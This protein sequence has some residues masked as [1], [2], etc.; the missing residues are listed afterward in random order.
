MKTLSQKGLNVLP[1]ST[2]VIDA[3]FKELKVSGIDV[4]GFGA[5][6]PDFETPDN[7]KTAG[8]LAI[9]KGITRYT[10]VAGLQ[11]LREAVCRKFKRDYNLDYKTDQ[12]VV[13][14]GAKQ[15]IYNA[16]FAIVNPGDEVII[17]MP[18][19]ISYP[20]MAIMCGGIPVYAKTTGDNGFKVSA[21]QIEALVTPKT[22][23]IIL[24]SPSNPAGTV[25]DPGELD[26]IAEIV[27]K[28]DLYIISDEIYE[29]L[30]YDGLEFSSISMLG[31][32]ICRR[33]IIINGVSK[34][35]AMTGWRIGF[36]ASSKE[37]AQVMNNIQSHTTSNCSSIGQYA[38]IE[39]LDGQQE[40]VENMRKAFQKRAGL[41]GSAY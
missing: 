35:Y 2:L 9:E 27:I 37:L 16:L 8:K 17:P 40:D 3:M 14:N 13:S 4:L 30:I 32:E 6:E 24:N 25:Y 36:S 7:I 41:Y 15:S 12:I 29:K 10:P 38:S 18:Y 31:E 22:K 1:S 23:A 5:G 19:W 34:S 20:Q 28:H 21:E 11:E 26:K 33:T 39:A